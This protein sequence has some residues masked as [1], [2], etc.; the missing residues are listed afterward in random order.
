MGR[1]S[2]PGRLRAAVSLARSAAA[3][4]ARSAE[5]GGRADSSPASA[6]E[7]MRGHDS[8]VISRYSVYS[9]NQETA[10]TRMISKNKTTATSL[11]VGDAAAGRGDRSGDLDVDLVDARARWGHHRVAITCRRE[12]AQ[13]PGP[14]CGEEPEV[15][16]G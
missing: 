10:T 16:G 8:S 5:P 3:A 11:V 14:G 6:L 12:C 2:K 7:V 15:A 4:T 13:R 1:S 9:A